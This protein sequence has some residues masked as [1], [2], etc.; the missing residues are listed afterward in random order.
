MLKQSPYEILEL[1]GDFS[2][3][4]IK[5]A[6]R[7]AIRENPPE[8]SPEIFSKISSA[9]ESLTDEN[10]FFKDMSENRFTLSCDIELTAD[11]KIDNAKYLK[12]MFEVPFYD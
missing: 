9:Y 10:Y 3:R 4:D 8:Q 2:Y 7:K 5:K 6:Y 12:T 11:K 1:E